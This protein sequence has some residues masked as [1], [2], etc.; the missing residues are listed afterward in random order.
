[1]KYDLAIIGGG[2]SGASAAI[3]ASSLGLKTIVIDEQA[4]A[5][6]QFWRAKNSSIKQP[7][8]STESAAGNDLRDTLGASSA[9]FLHSTRVWHLHRV[10]DGF[11]LSIIGPNGS[12]TIDTSSLA[13]AGGALERV[14]PVPGWTL[15]GVIGLGAATA[16]MKE[17][18]MLPGQRVV[19]AGVGPLLFFVAHEILKNGGRVVGV[20][21]LNPL[22]DWLRRFP[23]MLSRPDL[24]MR[25]VGWQARLKL[26]G[27]P[28]LHGYG[29]RE[30]EGESDVEKIHVG[31]VTDD[32]APEGEITHSF[33]A[34]SLCLGHGLYP[35]SEPARMLGAIH[36]YDE[37]QGGWIPQTD[38]AGRTTVKN[39]VAI[40]DGAGIQGAAA[41]VLRGRLGAIAVAKDMDKVTADVA[42]SRTKELT[43]QL[44]SA[45]RFGLAMTSLTVPKTGILKS[46]APD[47]MICRCEG[48]SRSALEAEIR[49][50]GDM[51]NAL[52]SATRCGMGPCGGKFC[53]EVVSL[54]TCHVTGKTPAELGLSTP[55]S[56]LRPVSVGALAGEFDYDDLPIPE[57]APQ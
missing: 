50:G 9:E 8:L 54:L 56:P 29:I 20:V 42:L 1:M 23:N 11:Q 32:W 47:T 45:R 31:R 57:P 48:V 12:Q 2:P 15:P 28:V 51:P 37:Q 35:A 7:V 26:R 24:L 36:S 38:S 55:R 4:Q 41:A 13:L 49:S 17:H 39:L 19:V 52:K 46:I 40:G 43:R 25:G 27:V 14:F 22:G 33:N 6:G 21:D 16:L 3:E 53:A 30:I 44:G 5:G 10:G 18:V 34:D